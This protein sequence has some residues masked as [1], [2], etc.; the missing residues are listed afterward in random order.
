MR[1][2]VP[3]PYVVSDVGNW[4]APAVLAGLASF[5]HDC[6]RAAGHDHNRGEDDQQRR[7][8]CDL[9]T[10]GPPKP[11]GRRVIPV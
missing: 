3:G 8:H 6:Q 11:I 7:L 1:L 9:A 5:V 4:S 10:A 2:T